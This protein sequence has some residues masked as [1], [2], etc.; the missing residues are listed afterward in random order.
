VD[1]AGTGCVSVDAPTPAVALS[2]LAQPSKWPRFNAA[3]RLET[4]FRGQLAPSLFKCVGLRPAWGACHNS[5]ASNLNAGLARRGRMRFAVVCF[6]LLLDIGALYMV[7]TRLRPADAVPSLL[8][9]D[10]YLQR[11]DVLLRTAF[12]SQMWTEVT[13]VWGVAGSTL[14]LPWPWPTH[15]PTQ[16]FAQ[17]FCSVLAC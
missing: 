15:A 10:H 14:T 11:I 5:Y 12:T 16:P 9:A 3:E 4:W 1:E 2:A 6:F 13:I 17:S 8:P 7:A